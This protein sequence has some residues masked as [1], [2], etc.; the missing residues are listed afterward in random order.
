MFLG[1]SVFLYGFLGGLVVLAAITM[2]LVD[3]KGTL[4][5]VKYTRPTPASLDSYIG[6]ELSGST[7]L[8]ASG[9]LAFSLGIGYSWWV[10][11]AGADRNFKVVYLIS[12]LTTYAAVCFVDILTHWSVMYRFRQAGVRFGYYFLGVP[13]EEE[14]TTTSKAQLT[15]S[16]AAF[17]YAVMWGALAIHVAIGVA[18]IYIEFPT[19]STLQPYSVF[20]SVTAAGG[21]VVL[22]ILFLQAFKVGGSNKASLRSLYK[23][24]V[25]SGQVMNIKN[26][27]INTDLSKFEGKTTKFAQ[28]G[29]QAHP[30]DEPA[31]TLVKHIEDRVLKEG[32]PYGLG[33]HNYAIV[34]HGHDNDFLVL[35]QSMA[36]GLLSEDPVSRIHRAKYGLLGKKPKNEDDAT[37][38]LSAKVNAVLE[39]R[40]KETKWKSQVGLLN[41]LYVEE[42]AYVRMYHHVC[43][44]GLGFGAWYNLS[45]WFPWVFTLYTLTLNIQVLRDGGAGALL[46]WLTALIP[47]LLSEFGY[48]GG[49][50]QVHAW[51]QMLGT[52]IAI[53]PVY[54]PTGQKYIMTP[55]V[56][57]D[58]VTPCLQH[59]ELDAIGKSYDAQFTSGLAISTAILFAIMSTLFLGFR[60]KM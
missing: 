4:L 10:G 50:A 12:V 17:N 40:N 20:Q 30:L 32:K 55:A 19:T 6:F 56:I 58:S 1:N 36:A 35:D 54:L 9:W 57:L 25:D 24:L 38:G 5:S 13:L 39:G 2:S 60:T 27:K 33:L 22:L 31:V 7:L 14:M 29:N 47:L 37:D 49:W 34:Q 59:P 18:C 46:S 26:V 42:P 15:Y 44:F 8:L 41:R 3:I 51:G 23:G 11:I 43:G 45:A 52:A 28:V 16:L 48:N 21:G 53:F